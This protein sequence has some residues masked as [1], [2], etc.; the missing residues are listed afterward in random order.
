MSESSERKTARRAGLQPDLDVNR[1]CADFYLLERLTTLDSREAGRLLRSLENRL[2]R[3][4]SLYLDMIL[5][6]ELRYARSKVQWGL[7]ESCCNSA[8]DDVIDD[9]IWDECDECQTCREYTCD[10]CPCQKDKP[11]NLP[12]ML[13]PIKTFIIKSSPSRNDAWADWLKL[14]KKKGLQALSLA[15]EVFAMDWQSGYGG[16][17]WHSVARV[18]LDYTLGK[19]T[20]RSFIDRC[21]TLEHNNGNVFNK[22]YDGNNWLRTVLEKQAANEYEWLVSRASPQVK[23]VWK[24][25]SR[26][27]RNQLFGEMDSVWLGVQSID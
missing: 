21:W 27:R 15:T 8:Y 12:P 23:D 11:L 16:P 1:A 19:M 17:G 24:T 10:I 9:Q 5:G 2:T 4:F 26:E 14:R 22:L 13:N 6:G 25:H 20:D 18:L 7:S 3:E